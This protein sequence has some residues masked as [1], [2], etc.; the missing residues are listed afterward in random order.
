[1]GTLTG[2]KYSVTGKL[3]IDQLGS[4]GGEILTNAANITLNRPPPSF[5]DSAGLNALSKLNTNATGSA[6]ALAGGQNY[7]TAGNFTNN[8]TL[9][10]GAG[11]KFDVNGN[12]TNFSGSMLTGGTYGITGTLQFNGANIV[13]NAANITLTG[14]TSQ[15]IDQTSANGL[16]N[17]AINA[18][19][20]V[21]SLAGRNLTTAGAF[22][23]AGTLNIGSGSKFLATT[24]FTQSSTGTT[25]Y[26]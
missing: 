22:S 13:T 10:V 4:T 12:L 17:F 18:A 26:S 7:T 21:F 9:T 20:G 6:F 5:V 1:G 11:S 15:I 23:N 3:Q 8:G 25:S 16:R 2:G 14:A 24:G 19:T